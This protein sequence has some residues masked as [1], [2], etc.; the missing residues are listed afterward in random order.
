LVYCIEGGIILNKNIPVIGIVFLFVCSAFIPMSLGINTRITDTTEQSST[1]SRGETLYVGGNGDGNYSSIQDAIDNASD[2]DTVFVYDDSSPY[3]ENVVVHKSINLIGEDRNTTI[4]DGNYIWDVLF[5]F[6]DW[7]NISRFTIR[8]G[9]DD[10][11]IV[12]LGSSSNIIGNTISNNWMGIYLHESNDNTI[13]GNTISNNALGMLLGRHSSGNTITDNA[14]SNNGYGIY[15]TSYSNDHTITNNIITNNEY[16]GIKLVDTSHNIITGNNISNNEDGIYLYTSNSNT[17]TGN[18]ISSN[19]YH[20]ISLDW[21]SSSNTI[22]GN[23][24]SNNED[25]IYLFESSDNTIMGNTISNNALGMLLG[26][27]SSGNTITDNTFSGNSA[28]LGLLGSDS[29]TIADNTFS[30]NLQGIGL[31]DSSSNT[32]TGNSISNNDVL[33]IHLSNSCH[34]TIYHNN[35]INN[36]EN[37]KDESVNTWDDGKYGNYWSDYEERYPDAKPRLLK[38]WMWNTP[39]EITGG[40]NKD[41][42]PLVNQWPKSKPRTIQKDLASYSSYLLRFLEQFPIL[43]LLLQR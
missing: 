8:N 36:G 23:I 39:Y 3:Y 43:R 34:N 32:F 35:F 26:R 29:N 41:R 24:I 6:A 7:V 15:L 12:L 19:Y 16:D 9:G 40:D 11:G 10:G 22:T 30:Y 13:M 5:V 31:K 33:A 18:T 20:G 4:I 17:I 28:G 27:H 2:E 42:C 21:N 38:P 14:I 25:G 1:I 37:A